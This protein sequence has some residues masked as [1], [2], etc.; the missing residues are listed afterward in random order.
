MHRD[1]PLTSLLLV[2]ALLAR[3]TAAQAP[4]AHAAELQR[5]RAVWFQEGDHP[6]AAEIGLSFAPRAFDDATKRAWNGKAPGT[7]VPLAEQA[8]AEL[9]SFTDLEFGSVKVKAG[10]YYTVLEQ[11]KDGWRLGLLDADKVRAAQL[12]PGA[13]NQE[14]L[15]AAIPMQSATG[16]GS[17]LQLAIDATADDGS[18]A[19]VA[20]FGPHRLSAMGRVKGV[21]NSAPITMQDARSSQ[22][23]PLGP[24]V[25]GRTPFAVL[26]HGLPKWNTQLHEACDALRP[27]SPWRLGK[28]W[29]TT[30]DTNAAL[31]LGGK[32]LGAGSWHLALLKT[33]SSWSLVVT[34]APADYRARLD[35]FAAGQ[36][37][38]VLEVPLRQ[39]F[40][41]PMFEELR[42]HFEPEG[43]GLDLVIEFG[44]QRLSLPFALAKG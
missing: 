30:L 16:N 25:A 3:P 8:W 34:S 12:A 35:A 1:A 10:A 32:K 5:C 18:F 42:L 29:A 44:P 11:G 28:D 23:V 14:P 22:H 19:L 40:V 37:K 33:E 6:I 26:D 41:K 39:E 21:R 31:Q 24:T 15:L 20:Q 9:V 7:R 36:G 38:P 17:P 2:A 4:T 43:A 27:G 13:T